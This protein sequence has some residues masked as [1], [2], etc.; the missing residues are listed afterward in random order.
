MGSCAS[1]ST[2]NDTAPTH[3]MSNFDSSRTFAAS[4]AHGGGDMKPETTALV[5]IEFQNEFTTEGGKLHDGV[6]EVMMLNDMLA[7]SAQACQQAR[8]KGMRVIHAPISF[9][10]G[11]VDNPN[12]CLGILKGCHDGE[13]FLEKTWNSEICETMTPQPGDLI[14]QGK[15]GLDAFPGT[16]L[17]ALLV[18]NGIQTVV[19]G[20]F[21]T[22]CCVESTMRTAFEKG[23]NVVT[24]TDC[25]ATTSAEGQKAA[26]EGTFTFFSTPL[27]STQFFEKFA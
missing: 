26:T 3:L 18:Q 5:M 23:F 16:N 17:E 27:T 7:K 8:A 9:A 24:L 22:N 25:T 13:L 21:L 10:K 6:K 14:V 12:K 1:T 15:K 19:L 4:D 11:G 20:G 2:V